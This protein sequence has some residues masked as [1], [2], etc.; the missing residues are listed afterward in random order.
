MPGATPICLSSMCYFHITH[1]YNKQTHILG[2]DIH[3]SPPVSGVTPICLS[4]M[5]YFHITHTYIHTH[6]YW[7]QTYIY[8]LLCLAQR[9]FA[10]QV[11]AVAQSCL[12]PLALHA[13]SP[14]RASHLVGGETP[15]IEWLQV[16][17]RV[18]MYNVMM[19]DSLCQM[20]HAYRHPEE[21]NCVYNSH[22]IRAHE[23]ACSYGGGR[24]VY[25][26]LFHVSSKPIEAL[27]VLQLSVYED[28]PRSFSR[29]FSPGNHIHECSFAC[30]HACIFPSIC[31]C[32]PGFRFHLWQQF[33]YVT[34]YTCLRQHSKQ[35]VF[36]MSPGP[37]N[38]PKND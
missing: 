32:A 3:I 4:S 12:S 23:Q 26:C 37:K 6:T 5:C 19:Y 11:W 17:G 24:H 10:C 31:V 29:R 8:H 2:S 36:K 34:V 16:P 25:V 30:L 20:I 13:L 15:K 1:T 9:L 7:A 18:C 28:F 21:A 35:T 33:L 27:Q 22:T 14:R 38:E